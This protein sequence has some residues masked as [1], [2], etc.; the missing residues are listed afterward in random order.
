MPSKIF[1]LTLPKIYILF[2][3]TDEKIVSDY[4]KAKGYNHFNDLFDKLGYH[5][6]SLSILDESGNPLPIGLPILVEVKNGRVCEL[7]HSK[8]F[9]VLSLLDE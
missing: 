7:S 4:A 6:Y 3:M 1:A 5:I 8:A 2:T 9:D